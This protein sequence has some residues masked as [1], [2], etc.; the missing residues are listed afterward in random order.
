M[1]GTPIA[2]ASWSAAES[3]QG[4]VSQRGDTEGIRGLEFAGCL[5]LPK[6][7]PRRK[8]GKEEDSYAARCDYGAGSQRG[9]EG[10]HGTRR[11]LSRKH[12]R[13]LPALPA[14]EGRYDLR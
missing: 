3:S 9:D 13:R 2:A 5:P 4:V 6:S 1:A 11:R 12:I 14:R 10:S 8:R 7:P